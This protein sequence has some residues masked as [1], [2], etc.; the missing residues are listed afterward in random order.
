MVLSLVGGGAIACV[1]Y[2]RGPCYF[3]RGQRAC[4]VR[5]QEYVATDDPLDS[6]SMHLPVVLPPSCR[7]PWTSPLRIDRLVLRLL[8]MAGRYARSANS[9]AAEIRQANGPMILR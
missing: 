9:M 7:L 1:A 4:I 2:V 3:D 6:R 5:R 8:R